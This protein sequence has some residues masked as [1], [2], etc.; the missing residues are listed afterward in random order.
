[1]NNSKVRS[2]PWGGGAKGGPQTNANDLPTTHGDVEENLYA[3][4]HAFNWQ[5]EAYL[6]CFFLVELQPPLL[7]IVILRLIIVVTSRVSER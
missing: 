1:M 3:S 6:G 5:M 4:S 7:Y 2:G